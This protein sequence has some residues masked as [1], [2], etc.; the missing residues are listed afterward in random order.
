MPSNAT[1]AGTDDMAHARTLYPLVLEDHPHPAGPGLRQRGLYVDCETTGFNSEHDALIEL[2]ML[3]FTYTTS[4]AVT[5]VHRDQ[6]RTWRQ[7]P[8]R[9]VRAEITHITGLTDEDLAG[10][11][12]DVPAAAELLAVSNLVVAHNARFDR[13]F[14]ERVVPTARAAP[15][16]CSR[17][18]VPWDPVTFPSRALACLL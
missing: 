9:P 8:D 7:D 3:P 12:I 16:A 13:P 5:D 14:V 17:H 6:A 10:Q 15:W 2:A 18:E 11:A 1:A 4:G